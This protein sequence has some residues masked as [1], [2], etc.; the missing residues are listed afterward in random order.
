ME[1]EYP[2]IQQHDMESA[3][4]DTAHR[5]ATETIYASGAQVDVFLRTDNADVDQ[6][7]D[8]DP[9]PTYWPAL[10]CK[11][12]FVP[13]PLEIALKNWGLD[14][15]VKLEL[16]FGYNDI[17]QRFERLLRSGDV[18]KIP[19][20]AVGNVTPKL[21]RVVNASPNQN[22]K[23]SWL[24]LACTAESLTGDITVQPIQPLGGAG[25]SDVNA[26]Q[27]SDNLCE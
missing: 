10:V 7:W 20:N 19:F 13:K 17:L 23:Y 15:A 11:A 26:Q 16:I 12:F 8:E 3:D 9:D 5:V 24:F 1:R 18:I 25:V 6:V 4:L 2:L 22:F 21:F 14:T 27:L